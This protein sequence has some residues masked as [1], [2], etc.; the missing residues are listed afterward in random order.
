MYS[1]VYRSI[2]STKPQWVPGSKKLHTDVCL[3]LLAETE[4]SARNKISRRIL[5]DSLKCLENHTSQFPH[6]TTW[7]YA[8]DHWCSFK[9]RVVP[10]NIILCSVLQFTLLYSTFLYCILLFINLLLFLMPL[11]SA[12]QNFLVFY[13][14]SSLFWQ[15]ENKKYLWNHQVYAVCG[16]KCNRAYAI[17]VCFM[18]TIQYAFTT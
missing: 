2:Y 17:L 8:Q 7:Q 14:H 11:Y 5:A 13:S 6:K 3:V 12:S 4:A 9:G 10:T 18:V 15:A 1:T 16:H